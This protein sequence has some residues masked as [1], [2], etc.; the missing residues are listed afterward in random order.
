MGRYKKL[1]ENSG[2][3]FIANFGSK[4]ISFF[5]V[6]F[7]TEYLTTTEYGNLDLITTTVSLAIP[8]IT[9]CITEAVLRF[10]I[11]DDQNRKKI[12]SNGLLMV[13]IGNVIFTLAAPI[14]MTFKS[15]SDYILWLYLL[16]ITNSIFNVTAHFT[17]GIGK[18][19]VFALSGFIHTV[20][21]IGLNI[22]L[23]AVFRWGI[24]GYLISSVVSNVVVIGYLITSGRLLDYIGREIDKGY[25][26]KM[27]LYSIPLIPNALCWW[28][29]QSADRYVIAAMMT[30]ADNG[31]YAAANKIPTI[32][33]TVSSIFLQAW[34]LS[35]VEEANS[36]DKS[37][38]F[39]N[40][41]Q[42]L[43]AVLIIVASGIMFILQPL[44]HVFVQEDYYSGWT[45]V[46]PLLVAMIF[47]CFSSYLGTNYVAMKKTKGAFY[48]TI[49]GAIVNI[50]L[51]ILL[52]PIWGINGT[53]FA[54]AISFL[55]TWLIRSFDTRKF[56]II[57]YRFVS[58]FIPLM[59]V[60]IQA[61]ILS[62]GFESLWINLLIVI[63]IMATFSKQIIQVLQKVKT[64]RR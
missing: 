42:M 37:E 15:I 62:I 51:N 17:R 18:T 14:L 57:K 45:C 6:R 54:T 8:I 36:E 46:P 24:Q 1:L 56:V 27:L 21:Q 20:V 3:F 64:L 30:S 9:L 59:L 26:K 12:L 35:S 40:V 39:S 41:F 5:L 50:I 25:L 19:K 11:D 28:I 10:S 44:Y 4:L 22:V 29:M 58:F 38:F 16:T 23:L 49:I 61:V 34:Q 53:A 13:F 43:A 7:Y 48:T 47:S 55:I 63:L 33:T 32:I 52:T 60:I 31:L 2:V